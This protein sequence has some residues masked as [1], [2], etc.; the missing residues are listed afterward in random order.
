MQAIFSQ[1]Q[2]GMMSI[3][4][5]KPSDR[6]GVIHSIIRSTGIAVQ[7]CTLAKNIRHVG[8]DTLKCKLYF[9]PKYNIY[10]YFLIE[11]LL[12]DINIVILIVI[13]VELRKLQ[14]EGYLHYVDR[15]EIQNDKLFPANNCFS[16]LIK[17]DILD[18]PDKFF[19][20]AVNPEC[21][22]DMYT[23]HFDKEMDSTMKKVTAKYHGGERNIFMSV[24]STMSES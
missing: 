12:S 8:T 17:K 16:T 6:E 24:M 19:H 13:S 4:K 7:V 3:S 18:M 20:L 23:K 2:N 10:F 21:N 5:P 9:C 15:K 14:D 22:R 11:L 1:Q